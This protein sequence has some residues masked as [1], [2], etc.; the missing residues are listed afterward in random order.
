MIALN[1]SGGGHSPLNKKK[2]WGGGGELECLGEKL[3]CLGGGG[4]AYLIV[5]IY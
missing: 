1:G 3:E 4:L 5:T 2:N